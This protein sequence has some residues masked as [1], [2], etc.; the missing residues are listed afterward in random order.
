MP[1]GA[2]RAMKRESWYARL[3]IR[4]W[5][6]P[7][8]SA[9]SAAALITCSTH[10]EACVNACLT[11]NSVT[12]FSLTE[13]SSKPWTERACRSH[14]SLRLHR[15][16]HMLVRVALQ[17]MGNCQALKSARSRSPGSRAL[18][19]SVSGKDGLKVERGT[20]ESGGAFRRTVVCQ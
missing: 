20:G 14:G 3:T 18:N 4:L 13:D 7:S 10:Q 17:C 1:V 19:A 15:K 9:A 2:K 5:L 11:F 8:S 16:L 12:L 6:T